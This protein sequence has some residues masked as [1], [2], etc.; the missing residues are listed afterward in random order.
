MLKR[1]DKLAF[2]TVADPTKA[3][4]KKLGVETSLSAPMHP[5]ASAASIT[6]EELF[7]PAAKADSLQ[8][9]KVADGG[10][11]ATVAIEQSSHSKCRSPG[12]KWSSH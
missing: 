12:A 10:N 1:Q 8:T 2:D 5:R 7:D 9:K 11:P 6:V 3:L 4:Y